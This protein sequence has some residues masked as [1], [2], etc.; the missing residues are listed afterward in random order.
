MSKKDS[1]VHFIS[2]VNEN[3]EEKFAEVMLGK[4]EYIDI[5]DLPGDLQRAKTHLAASMVYDD[6]KINLE[7]K[8]YL[9]IN[10]INKI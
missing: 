9:L 3:N 10:I 6:T 1:L 7:S 4:D 5:L 8:D 2:E